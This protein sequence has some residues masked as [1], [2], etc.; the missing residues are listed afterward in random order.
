M[1]NVNIFIKYNGYLIMSIFEPY[2]LNDTLELLFAKEIFNR[3][4]IL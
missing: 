3:I 2:R 4:N 1:T